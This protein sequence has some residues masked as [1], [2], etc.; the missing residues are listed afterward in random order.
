[1]LVTHNLGQLSTRNCSAAGFLSRVCISTAQP[2]HWKTLV[3]EFEK[4][5]MEGC[6]SKYWGWQCS[7]YF[8]QV[9]H[10]YHLPTFSMFTQHSLV[11]HVHPCIDQN[12][13]EL[14]AS[15]FFM[16]LEPL[17]P[18]WLWLITYYYSDTK[19]LKSWIFMKSFIYVWQDLQ[20]LVTIKKT[21][22]TDHYHW[23]AL[24]QGLTAD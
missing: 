10:R 18:E 20:V 17:T 21:I 19:I 2:R 11:M 22:D 3:G 16:I 7:S 23:Q 4:W 12:V 9:C 1:M 14:L 15:Q 5:N 24:L 8:L 13:T 6:S